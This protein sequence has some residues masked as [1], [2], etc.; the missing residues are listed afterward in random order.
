MLGKVVE[1]VLEDFGSLHL[2]HIALLFKGRFAHLDFLL[3]QS[4]VLELA[5]LNRALL[6]LLKPTG[7]LFLSLLLSDNLLRLEAFEGWAERLPLL[8]PVALKVLKELGITLLDAEDALVVSGVVFA[9]RVR[10]QPQRLIEIGLTLTIFV[11]VA[12]ISHVYLHVLRSILFDAP[13]H[14]QLVH[15]CRSYGR[16]IFHRGHLELSLFFDR[17]S[18]WIG[19]LVGEPVGAVALATVH[20]W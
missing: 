16:R 1:A 19:E 12:L 11:L 13:A 5:C 18:R 10:A 8:L 17:C 4:V 9:R 3:I 2:Q 7:L 14:S 6:G 15:F 20:F